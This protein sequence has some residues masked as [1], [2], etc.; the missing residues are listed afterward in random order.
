M[1]KSDTSKRLFWK[2]AIVDKLLMGVDDHVQAAVIK[3]SK[4]QGGTKLLRSVKYLFP[5]KVRVEDATNDASTEQTGHV[6]K[7]L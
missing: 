5:I 7:Q 3:V 1:L 6:D 2:L 4:P